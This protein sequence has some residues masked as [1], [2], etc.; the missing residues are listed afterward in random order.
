M[1]FFMGAMFTMNATV[2]RVN[3]NPNAD[4]D[5]SDIYWVSF[6]PQVLDGDTI[7]IEQENVVTISTFNLNKRLT[8]LGAGYSADTVGSSL[9]LT[10]AKISA[11]WNI[12]LTLGGEGSIFKGIVF[13][14]D[15]ALMF[16]S[17]SDTA[18]LL[19]ERCSFLGTTVESI[20]GSS[21]ASEVSF[22]QCYFFKDFTVGNHL[23][24][25]WTVKNCILRSGL[26]FNPSSGSTNLLLR[27][28]TIFKAAGVDY[29]H[30]DN[31]IILEFGSGST[32]NSTFNNT[33]VAN[34]VFCGL[35]A[36][37]GVNVGSLST[38][39]NNLVNQSVTQVIVFTSGTYE[40]SFELVQNSP[41]INGGVSLNGYKPD[42]GAYGGNNPYINAGIPNIPTIYDI[43]FPNGN[44][45]TSS[46]GILVDFKSRS[47]N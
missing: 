15:S 4:A 42:C 46:S 11:I 12:N 31:N 22:K 45:G 41:A 35:V 20:N 3:S 16:N 47:N 43:N 32:N 34:N 18:N 5:F 6:S 28:N 38:N 14:N 30:F 17:I 13:Y 33:T 39:G 23:I 27:N 24:H 37:S 44:S 21:L 10:S 19:F 26:E 7:H 25:N 40:T 29:A 8:I 2:W 9:P 36:P 1:V